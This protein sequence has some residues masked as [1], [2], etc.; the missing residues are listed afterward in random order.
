MVHTADVLRRQEQRVGRLIQR[1]I[2]AAP[3]YLI[4]LAWFLQPLLHVAKD[5]TGQTNTM[6]IILQ[7]IGAEIEAVHHRIHIESR[8]K[9]S[10]FVRVV[11][12]L[13]LRGS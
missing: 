6:R 2:K 5:F 9:T 4:A 12:Q 3:Q 13:G 7:R 11:S 10:I 8:T 1:G